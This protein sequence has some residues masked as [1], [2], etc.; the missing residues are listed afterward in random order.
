VRSVTG[1]VTGDGEDQPIRRSHQRGGASVIQPESSGDDDDSGDEQREMEKDDDDGLMKAG[2]ERD[3]VDGVHLERLHLKGARVSVK[4]EEAVHLQTWLEREL[5]DD[6]QLL[7]QNEPR[8]LQ[9]HHNHNSTLQQ[10]HTGMGLLQDAFGFAAPSAGGIGV[11]GQQHLGPSE[12]FDTHMAARRFNAPL[13]FQSSPHERMPAEG[14]WLRSMY[15]FPTMSFSSPSQHPWIVCPFFTTLAFMRQGINGD[16][17]ILPLAEHFIRLTEHF[18]EGDLNEAENQL[19]RARAQI[20]RVFDATRVEV[21]WSLLCLTWWNRLLLRDDDGLSKCVYYLALS[22]QMCVQLR[23]PSS[24]DV[25]TSA[26]LSPLQPAVA[27]D[28]PTSAIDSTSSTLS[29]PSASP[30]LGMGFSRSSYTQCVSPNPLIPASSPLPSL[31]QFGG[32][33]SSTQSDMVSRLNRELYACKTMKEHIDASLPYCKIENDLLQCLIVT[34]DLLLSHVRGSTT[35]SSGALALIN[36]LLYLP[37]SILTIYIFEL[38]LK[39][40]LLETLL[41]MLPQYV[42]AGQIEALYHSMGAMHSLLPVARAMEL[43]RF[44]VRS[45]Q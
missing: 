12:L 25:A 21:A 37:P 41:A 43:M 6:I 5:E 45:S 29:P 10:G 13:P 24:H 28:K 34:F 3:G 15:T 8:H 2:N 32:G 27:H 38:S 23:L 19:A 11:G 22:R 42:N 36:H 17:A 33:A 44:S 31:P 40:H 26:H 14:S 4:G 18:L 39:E 20:S 16:Q 7:R 30:S 35:V 1:T 9:Q